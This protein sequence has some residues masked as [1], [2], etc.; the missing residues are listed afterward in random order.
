MTDSPPDLELKFGGRLVEQ[1]GA[2]MYP[3]A[4]ATVAELISNAWDADARNVWVNMPFGDWA[5]GEIVV[6][7]D[8]IGMG[9]DEA[10]NYYLIVGRNRRSNGQQRTEGGRLIHGRKGIGKLAAFGTASVLEVTTKKAGSDPVSFR[11][12]YDKIRRQDPTSPYK[13]ET[14]TDLG[15]LVDPLTGR[16]LEHGTRIRLSGLRLKRRLNADRFRSSMSR[17]F[18]LNDHEMSVHINGQPLA[19]FELDVEL[20]FPPDR[21]PDEAELDGDW[22]VEELSNGREVRWWMG[23]TAKPIKDE[24]ERGVS[25]IVRGK[26]AQRPFMFEAGGGTTGQLGQEYLVGEVIADWIDDENV[27]SGDDTDYIQSN[28]DQLQLE[29]E[30][31]RPFLEWGRRRVRWALAARGEFKRDL[32]KKRLE[33]NK[34][35]QKLLDGRPSR[36]RAALNRVADAVGRLPEVSE[37]QIVDVMSAVV[38]VRDQETARAL[39]QDIVLD[40]ADSG[41]LWGLLSELSEL[42]ARSTQALLAAR[43]EAL[44]QLRDVDVS[45]ESAA[46]VELLR[47]GPA[48]LDPGWDRRRVVE[49]IQ[50]VPGVRV[51]VVEATSDG[52]PPVVIVLQA[53]RSL[54]TDIGQ[55]VVGLE[56]RYGDAERIV[57][58]DRTESKAVAT[59]SDVL[60]RSEESHLQWLQLVEDRLR[61]LAE[62]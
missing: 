14:S 5:D 13:V 31:L 41:R 51:F 44:A 42:D 33:K 58:A 18:A 50:S 26:L 25:V 37:Q 32:R 54:D 39:A 45:D 7:D 28:R 23:F 21:V 6:V 3:S 38:G 53:D 49:D 1:L 2:Q 9:L 34:K 19:K 46:I 4:T 52:L 62:G 15:P 35:L 60:R 10:G 56:D 47:S 12:D 36:E 17:R 16:A 40:G 55:V 48:L 27:T 61:S 30:D 59:W 57:F 43:V 29:D 24:A 20:R 11:L 8:G 22:V